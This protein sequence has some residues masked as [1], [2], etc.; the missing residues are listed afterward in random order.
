MALTPVDV[1][2]RARFE[3]VAVVLLAAAA[4]WYTLSVRRVT[5]RG[6][7]WPA[8]RSWAFAAAWLCVA[9]PVCSGLYAFAPTN[10]SAYG[11]IYI[12][13]GLAGP[14]FLAL[15][16]PLQVMLLAHPERARLLDYRVTKVISHPLVTWVLFT[17]SMFVLFFT[18]LFGATLASAATAQAV[19]LAWIV[20][21]YLHYWP[22]ADADPSPHRLAYWP[23]IL[24][25]L[26]TFPVYAIVGMG[27]ESQ[28][29][30]IS[31][32]ISLGSLHLGAAV[33]WVAG[34][35]IA[36]SGAIA[37]FSQWLRADQRRA[38]A[39]DLANAAAAD[40]QL[41][42]WRESRDAAARAAGPLT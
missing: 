42:L 20:I 11:S 19:Y 39:N 18:G 25:L 5:R 8:L 6:R 32:G 17:G 2:T 34:E 35:T 33:V 13:V 29:T 40:R 26:L 14:A 37:V 15:A 4:A 36:L 38:R 3:P 1:F 10:F 21:G 23:R 9:V 12:A 7:E 28:L 16:G 30:R 31:A 22:V 24:Y 41:A 27:L